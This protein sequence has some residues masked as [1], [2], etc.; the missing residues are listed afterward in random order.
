MGLRLGLAV[1]APPAPAARVVARR[2]R[3]SDAE[4][5]ELVRWARDGVAEAEIGRRLGRTPAAVVRRL[6]QVDPAELL[7]PGLSGDDVVDTDLES[8]DVVLLELLA[9]VVADVGGRHSDILRRRLG[10]GGEEAAT[11]QQLGLV[12]GVTRERIRQLQEKALVR[13]RGRT[14]R[15]PV[16][17][18]NASLLS[19]LRACMAAVGT[20]AQRRGRFLRANFPES[21]AGVIGRTVA[22]IDPL[23]TADD[24]IGWVVAHDDAVRHVERAAWADGVLDR[25]LLA[26]A[27]PAPALLPEFHPVRDVSEGGVFR[28][29]RLGRDVQVESALEERFFRL[30]DFSTVVESFCEQPLRIEYP[31]FDGPHQYVP[32][33]AVVFADGRCAV[34]EVKPAP[35]WADTRNIAKWNAALRFCAARGWSFV[36]TD[37]RHTPTELAASA[38]DEGGAILEV[39]TR[40]GPAEWWQLESWFTSG[41]SYKDLVGVALRYGFALERGPLVVHRARRSPWLR[42]LKP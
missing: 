8:P 35:L 13:L 11:L 26:T 23:L 14:L 41:R 27:V 42:S 5:A 25:V 15:R 28:S 18:P 33:A 32:D 12:H 20:D 16:D 4:V 10:L 24:A 36:V 7:R 37:G 40:A 39:A 22:A 9:Q 2:G 29:T 38:D 34:V 31:W 1:E 19:R 17:S 3:W 30:L 6:E 21:H